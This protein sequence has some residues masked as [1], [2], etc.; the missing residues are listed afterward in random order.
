[1][2]AVLQPTSC[3]YRRRVERDETMKHLDDREAQEEA[4]AEVVTGLVTMLV[5][6]VIL[7]WV[8]G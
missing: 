7:L 2:V 3:V 8:Y 4:I 5:L 1:M 6:L